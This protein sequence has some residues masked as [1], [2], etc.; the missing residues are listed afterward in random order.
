MKK[1]EVEEEKDCSDDEINKVGN[2]PLDPRAGRV[3]VEIP[4]IKFN[5]K[6]LADVLLKNKFTKNST[7]P[8]RREINIISQQ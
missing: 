2:G 1:I 8:A 6:L 3:D 4:Q 7:V 5:A